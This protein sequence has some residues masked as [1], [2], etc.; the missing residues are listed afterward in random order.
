MRKS[1]Q[2]FGLSL[3]IVLAF[4]T[5]GIGFLFGID[6]PVPW[7]MIAVLAALPYLHQRWTARRF[8]SWR[9]DLSV[10]IAA[11]DEDHRKLLSLINNLQTAVYYPTGDAFERQAIKELVD[12]TKYH[13]QREEALMEQNG[14]P[15]FAAHKRQH[16]AMIARVGEFLSAYERD[17]EGTVEEMTAFLKTWL[18]DHIGGTDQKYGPYLRERGVG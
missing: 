16:E 13:F 18:I 10:G 7:I 11:I 15:D 8:V 14:Y 1:I 17:R 6:N 12:Y 4:M 5:I 3:F 9:E 2:T